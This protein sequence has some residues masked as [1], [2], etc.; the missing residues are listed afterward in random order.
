[1]MWERHEG[2]VSFQATAAVSPGRADSAPGG[3]AARQPAALF[4]GVRASQGNAGR[5]LALSSATLR[6]LEHPETLLS[7]YSPEFPQDRTV[8]KTTPC[9]S[10]WKPEK[11]TAPSDGNPLSANGFETVPC[12][13][14]V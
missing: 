7:E 11:V 13:K 4:D 3:R 10:G 2:G 1:M 9:V 8:S 6:R 12:R 5:K 14:L